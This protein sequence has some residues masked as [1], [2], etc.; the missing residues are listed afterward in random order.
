VTYFSMTAL[1]GGLGARFPAPVVGGLSA[2]QTYRDTYRGPAVAD[3]A[4]G[5][6]GTGVTRRDS[7][8]TTR[9]SAMRAHA[10]AHGPIHPARPGVLGVSGPVALERRVVVMPIGGA[11]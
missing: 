7:A 3:V 2:P 10:P 6:A 5:R 1:A 4:R 8:R 11:P 9:V